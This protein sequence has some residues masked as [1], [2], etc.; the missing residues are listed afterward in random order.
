MR[1]KLDVIKTAIAMDYSAADI[2]AL[3]HRLEALI[4]AG[5]MRS[6]LDQHAP[7]APHGSTA[8]LSTDLTEEIRKL[9]PRGGTD[10]E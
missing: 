8:A 9:G 1:E 7:H 4:G 3:D 6:M 5:E 2:S 10:E